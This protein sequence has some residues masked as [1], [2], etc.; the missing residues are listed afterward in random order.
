MPRPSLSLTLQGQARSLHGEEL[1]SGKEGWELLTASVY[2][3]VKWDK[4]FLAHRLPRGELTET[5]GPACNR[6][7]P[8]RPHTRA[9]GDRGSVCRTVTV[10]MKVA[11]LAVSLG[12]TRSGK[13]PQV[14][15]ICTGIIPI[16]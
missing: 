15:N 5:E 3:S 13:Y 11:S 1:L 2:P 7:V 9:T 16:L 14:A 12:L 8:A 6:K 10:F 4:E